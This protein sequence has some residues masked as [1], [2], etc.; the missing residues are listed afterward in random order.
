MTQRY[1]AT[2]TMGELVGET[3]EQE[4]KTNDDVVDKKGV[5][6]KVIAK[7]LTIVTTGIAVGSQIYSQYQTVNNSIAGDGISQARLNNQMAYLNEGLSIAGTIG[8]TALVNPALLPV[9]AIGLGIKY[10]MKAYQVA[11]QNRLK[12]ASWQSESI[13]NNEKQKRLVQDI[14]GVR[15]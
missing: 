5:D 2:F 8:V 4:K 6:T 3:K 1:E 7:T 13:V 10:S 11:Q 14:T 9:A 15:I 12:Q